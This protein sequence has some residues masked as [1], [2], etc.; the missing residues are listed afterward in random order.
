M[1]NANTAA[2]ND[3][4]PAHA[5][6]EPHG[7]I[8][9]DIVR[10]AEG[11]AA[12]AGDWRQLYA[13]AKPEQ[14]FLSE[15]WLSLW[16]KHYG[17]PEGRDTDSPLVVVT[18]RHNG[19]L[20]LVWPLTLVR[21]LG[22]SILKWAGEPVSQYGDVLIDPGHDAEALLEA[23]WQGIRS[24]KPDALVLRKTRA[25]SLASEFL[26]LKG[27]FVSEQEAAPYIDLDGIVCP[28]AQA[29]RYPSKDRK[30]RRRHRKRLAEQ[31]ELS[32]DW[33]AP[34]AQAGRLARHSVEMKR[35]WLRKCGRISKAFTDG[36]IESFLGDA[37]SGEVPGLDARVGV[38]SCGGK[39]A[40]LLVGFL[41]QGYYAGFLTAYD[42]AFERH[43]PG[44]LL[45][46]DAISA[47][48]GE[49]IRR[50]DL[51]APSDP[52]KHDWA[53]A[54]T[55]VED[56]CLPLTAGGRIYTRVIQS[57][58]RHGLKAGI[59]S[60]PPKLRRPLLA[61]ATILPALLYASSDS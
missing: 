29:E 55:G 52:Y 31:G 58:V 39:P 18:C 61:A 12:I 15:A 24:L 30:N 44:S 17:E 25:K 3:W 32:F 46:E 59:E 10:G 13:T 40:A 43:G 38:L 42:E 50:I 5:E 54:E 37:L 20:V 7:R 35:R 19:Q 57:G 9:I 48:I 26:L 27:A 36:R 51:L 16:H 21:R 22:L 45:F 1:V 6:G 34:S 49:K 47:A 23:A 53:S 41:N 8:A 60:L 11:L 56:L 28:K 33:L 4:V 14:V 2:L